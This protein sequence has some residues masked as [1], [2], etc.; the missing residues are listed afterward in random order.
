MKN[1]LEMLRLLELQCEAMLSSI[2][3]NRDGLESF[4]NVKTRLWYFRDSIEYIIEEL[5]EAK[6]EN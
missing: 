6:H 2:K 3:L 4:S 1:K 5:K